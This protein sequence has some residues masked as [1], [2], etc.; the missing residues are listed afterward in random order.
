[1]DRRPLKVRGKAWAQ[2][3][4][5]FIAGTGLTPNQISILSVVMALGSTICFYYARHLQ[6]LLILAALFIQLRLL[7]NL[8]DGMVAIEHNQKSVTG[9]I[10]ND[11]P[12]RFADIFIILGVGLAIRDIPY[13]LNLAWAA[14][15][16]A[17]LTAYIR[18]LGSS[19][20]TPSYFSGPMAKQHRM[21]LITVCCIAQ[22]V[23][24]KMEI[25]FNILYYCLLVLTFGS[26]LTSLLRLRK[27]INF[28]NSQE[29]H[30]AR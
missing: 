25:N 24:L 6:I 9:D 30:E 27:I 4:A 16:F 23:F 19:V 13:A 29:S 1:M 10:F 26:L 22:F 21:A 12:D 17:V 11:A 2:N 3:L 15:C 14:S 28:K 5:K 7:C 20:G 18:V 8:F